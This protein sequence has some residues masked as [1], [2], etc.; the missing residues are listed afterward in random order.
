MS[1][2][3]HSS[4]T[5]P[6]R[7]TYQC[8][9]PTE[10]TLGRGHLTRQPASTRL[11]WS[12][13]RSWTLSATERERG[14]LYNPSEFHGGMTTTKLVEYTGSAAITLHL[15]HTNPLM[16]STTPKTGS[17]TFRQ[18]LISLR[19]SSRA[20]SY[21]RQQTSHRTCTTGLLLASSAHLRILQLEAVVCVCVCLSNLWC[22]DN[23]C[24]INT[25][26]AE[27]LHG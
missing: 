26:S 10:Y 25:A 6:H 8:G 12:E 9:D 17:P 22:C 11:Q 2:A 18:K 1:Q 13:E 3:L 15:G 16:F 27:V 7:S 24:T 19:T 21:T 14:Q 4:K 23:D 5:S 20:T